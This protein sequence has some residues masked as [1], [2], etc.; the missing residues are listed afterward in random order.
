MCRPKTNAKHNFLLFI[1]NSL[2][3]PFIKNCRTIVI[4]LSFIFLKKCSNLFTEKNLLLHFKTTMYMS[5]ND[6]RNDFKQRYG[7][8][9]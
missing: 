1:Q 4:Y 8:I 9:N 6:K 2:I 3:L 7:T 5:I